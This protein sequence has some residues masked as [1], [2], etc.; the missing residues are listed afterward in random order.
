M[1]T[2]SLDK[3]SL[4]GCVDHLD[5][6]DQLRFRPVGRHRGDVI[7][8]L[9]LVLGCVARAVAHDVDEPVGPTHP[10]V[11][12]AMR[13]MEAR[14]AHRWTLTELATALHV[15]SGHL[16]RLFKSA[17]GLPPIAYLNRHRV[18]IAASL[19]LHTDQPIKDIAESVGWP[20]QNLFARR[21]KAHFGLSATTYRTRFSD[22][23]W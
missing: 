4:A 11:I 15:T 6:L 9:L 1:L 13:A 20:D 10:A 16:V 2:T 7:G 19:L 21:F 5:S 23:S 18:E 3:E 12:S 17:T 8:R 22:Q 14:L